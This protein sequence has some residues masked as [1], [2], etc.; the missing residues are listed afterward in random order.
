MIRAGQMFFSQKISYIS[1]SDTN[2]DPGLT[3]DVDWFLRQS[4]VNGTTKAVDEPPVATSKSDQAVELKKA[5]IK[6]TNDKTT[7]AEKSPVKPVVKTTA[8]T[9]EQTIPTKARPSIGT[10]Q[11]DHVLSPTTLPIITRKKS[12]SVSSVT[13]NTSTGSGFFNKLKGKFH[14]SPPTSPVMMLQHPFKD[15]YHL[16]KT[17]SNTSSDGGLTRTIS[18]T[19]N[20]NDPK[21][22]YGSDS[23]TKSDIDPKLD[24]YVKFYSQN[25]TS[26]PTSRKNS[27]SEGLGYTSSGDEQ[28]LSS[29]KLSSFLRRKSSNSVSQVLPLV[30]V[31]T[32]FNR[33]SNTIRD[34][35]DSWLQKYKQPDESPNELQPILPEFK[36]LKPLKRVAFHSSTFLIDP[37]QQIPSRS[38]RKGNV[39]VLPNGLLKIKPLT[40]ED[41]KAI[42]K[43][44]LGQGGG[45]VVGGTGA[46]HYVKSQDGGEEYSHEH[47]ESETAQEGK[48]DP[49]IDSKAKN[50][51]I[52]KPMIHSKPLNYTVPVEKMAL[53]SMYTRCCHLREILPI[54]AILKQIPKNSM[55][56]LPVLQLRNPTP[57]MVEI[58]TFADFIRIAPIICISLDGVQLSFKQFEILLSSMSAKT[59]LVKLSL[60]NTP[61]DENGWSL[62][63]WFLSRNTALNKLDITQCPSLTVNN[64]KKKKRTSPSDKTKKMEEEIQRMQS[65]KDNRSDRDWSLFTATIIA[66]GGIEELIL[67]G[68]CINDTNE[69]EN[70]IK[71]AVGIKTNR[72]GLAY[73]N[74]SSD[75]LQIL[76][77]HW[78]FNDFV[79]G[80]DLGFN[81]FLDESFLQSILELISDERLQKSMLKSQIGFI[82]LNSTN[83]KFSTL[84]KR[85][86]EDFLIRL[87][88][89]RYLDFS[90]NADLFC[91][92]DGTVSKDTAVEYFATKLPL[93]PKLVRLHL[94]NNKLTSQNIITLA[95]VLPFC[96]NLVY[97]SLIGNEIDSASAASL[98]QGVKN[99]RVITVEV[100]LSELPQYFKDR[101]GLYQMRNMERTVYTKQEKDQE[102]AETLTD[103]LNEILEIKAKG[104]LDMNSDL[105][106]KFLVKASRMRAELQ[107]AVNELNDL[108]LHKQLT[109][110]GK[111]ALVRLIFID[112]SIGKAIQ[113]VDETY[114]PDHASNHEST[115]NY[116]YSE[117][118]KPQSDASIDDKSSQNL[119]IQ[120]S[121]SMIKSPGLISRSS[122]KTSL[123]HLDKEEGNVHRL[124]QKLGLKD[125][126]YIEDT[127]SGEDIRKRI[128][129]INL[130]QLS[131][132]VKF[133][134][135]LKKKGVAVSHLFKQM[136]QEDDRTNLDLTYISNKLKT[137]NKTPPMEGNISSPMVQDSSVMLDGSSG[138]DINELFDEVLDNIKK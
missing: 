15:N 35:D 138:K 40:E 87:P 16:S 65:N 93:F 123:N 115:N 47:K 89:L 98:I 2:K 92:P 13:S 39:E 20:L 90:N 99:S 12:N 1:M 96:K 56:P 105:I 48:D 70:L 59:Q 101:L 110:E 49:K 77:N 19:L 68:C 32:E 66:R 60:R 95:N 127:M 37:P 67:T 86:L 31:A 119:S 122:S 130:E 42:E 51:A 73:N 112:S 41:K 120:G 107:D 44:Q 102:P 52:D 21:L 109:L 36:G 43:S 62:L 74:L 72:L 135:H 124:N 23:A 129:S 131:D 116:I 46:L 38:P 133:V 10:I 118:N 132:I 137:L 4:N 28:N 108:Q 54:P 22:K 134:E 117:L 25:E 82:S 45:L 30:S 55:A 103:E 106:Q 121:S 64:F 9:L 3:E 91:P 84:F 97:F 58:E 79:R 14:K 126:D 94:E 63:C 113:L 69:F 83:T 104:K 24:E 17:V 34:G 61:I 80:I 18:N 76:I 125:E 81:D 26:R 128:A 7:A 5:E 50:I 33:R 11:E 71:L 111:E 75:H 88:N 29:G 85:I 8:T 114:D 53:D 78:L 57:T 6:E 27:I 100:D 136:T